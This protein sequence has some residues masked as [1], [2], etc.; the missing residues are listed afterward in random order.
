MS[1][2]LCVV[3][4]CEVVDSGKGEPLV[5]FTIFVDADGKIYRLCTERGLPLRVMHFAGKSREQIALLFAPG[6]MFSAELSYVPASVR[7]E[8]IY[9]SNDRVVNPKAIAFQR[10]ATNVRSPDGTGTWERKSDSVR[11]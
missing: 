4:S 7:R 9:Q 10:A 2:F 6:A 5:E 3:R 1:Q 11:A 8:G